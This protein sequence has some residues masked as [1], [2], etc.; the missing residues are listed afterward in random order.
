MCDMVKDS[1]MAKATKGGTAGRAAVCGS[2][3]EGRAGPAVERRRVELE[4]AGRDHRRHR[5]V[6]LLCGGPKEAVDDVV[7]APVDLHVRV[8]LQELDAVQAW[9]ERDDFFDFFGGAVDNFENFFELGGEQKIELTSVSS[10]KTS[11]SDG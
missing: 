2:K 10:H 1:D 5:A 3:L 6:C 4:V 9:E 7:G 11:A 8:H